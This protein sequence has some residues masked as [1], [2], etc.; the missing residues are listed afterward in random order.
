LLNFGAFIAFIGVNAAALVH[1][2][3]RSQERVTLPLLIPAVGILVCA[4][5]WIHLSRNA[6]IL[7]TL[8]IVVGLVVAWL[9]RKSKAAVAEV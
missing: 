1:Y 8:W 6:Q 4:F 2:K 3:F 5:I 9:M 7:G